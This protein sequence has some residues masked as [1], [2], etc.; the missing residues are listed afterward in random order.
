MVSYLGNSQSPLSHV[1]AEF[2]L[3][4]SFAHMCGIPIVRDE[5]NLRQHLD[6]PFSVTVLWPG[7]PEFY[8]LMPSPS[9]LPQLYPSFSV[10]VA[11]SLVLS[12]AGVSDR[13]F[14]GRTGSHYNFDW[15]TLIWWSHS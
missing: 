3:P 15:K 13:T 7:E 2:Y 4:A 11:S 1:E 12:H 14:I 5:R 8:H 10:T 6:F 9:P